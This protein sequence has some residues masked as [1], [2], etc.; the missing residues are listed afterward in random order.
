MSSIQGGSL[1]SSL[2]ETVNVTRPSSVQKNQESSSAS[3]VSQVGQ[4]QS[5]PIVSQE[6]SQDRYQAS[7]SQVSEEVQSAMNQQSTAVSNVSTTLS[8]A[9]GSPTV[10]EIPEGEVGVA[11]EI[12]AELAAAQAAEEGSPLPQEEAT[13]GIPEALA[14]QEVERP[15][16]EAAQESEI[17]SVTEYYPPLPGADTDEEAYVPPLLEEEAPPV[18]I[19]N[20]RDV[21]PEGTAVEEGLAASRQQSQTEEDLDLDVDFQSPQD[22]LELR[23]QGQI[24][25][26]TPPEEPVTVEEQIHQEDENVLYEESA[27]NLR[28]LVQESWITQ[29]SNMSS[30]GEHYEDI[31]TGQ[32]VE[33]TQFVERNQTHDDSTI[34]E[35]N[36]YLHQIFGKDL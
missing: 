15:S 31:E 9:Q 18:D 32:P 29:A 2:R 24:D 4:V 30:M 16:V 5:A 26:L 19:D 22:T 35:E 10:A 1:L 20:E 34:A 36:T 13:P 8:E 11:A 33:V 23:N 14:E 3:E 7:L 6:L 28:D 25:P 21:E 17:P 27:A 12:Q